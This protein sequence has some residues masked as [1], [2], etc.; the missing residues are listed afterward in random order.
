MCSDNSFWAKWCNRTGPLFMLG[1]SFCPQTGFLTRL[2]S[3]MTLGSCVLWFREIAGISPEC[4]LIVTFILGGTWSIMQR[5][6]VYRRIWPILWCICLPLWLFQALIAIDFKSCQSYSWYT[7]TNAFLIWWAQDAVIINFS[8][9]RYGPS[10]GHRSH[11]RCSQ[12]NL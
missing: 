3:L 5:I 8:L 11:Y 10:G 12:Y 9:D 6:I 1:V 2:Q 4:F 7:L